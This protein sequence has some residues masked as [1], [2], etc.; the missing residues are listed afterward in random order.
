MS[1]EGGIEK[2]NRWR[3]SVE[4]HGKNWDESAMKKA[5]RVKSPGSVRQG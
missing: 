3:K 1:G 4:A 2:V 5:A